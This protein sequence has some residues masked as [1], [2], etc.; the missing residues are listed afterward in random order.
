MKATHRQCGVEDR[1][2]HLVA[3][4]ADV[5]VKINGRD[6]K[7]SAWSGNIGLFNTIMVKLSTF[8]G[9]K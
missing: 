1:V 2:F 4:T 3:G 9:N 8:K 7:R 5:F 6:W